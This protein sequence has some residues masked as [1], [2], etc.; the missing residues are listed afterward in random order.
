MILKC[1]TFEQMKREIIGQ[2]MSITVFGA[3]AIGTVTVPEILQQY[4]LLE[5]VLFYI[6]N[7]AAAQGQ[8]LDI[9][10]R[11]VDIEPAG[12]LSSMKENT[13]VIIAISRY[14]AVLEQLQN[15][16]NVEN[17][18]CYIMPMMCIHNFCNCASEGVPVLTD[19]PLIPKK[20]HYMWLGKKAMPDNL[21]KCIDSWKKYCPDYEIIRWDESNYDISKNSYMKDAYEAGAYG[22]VP[23]YAR[24]DILHQHGGLY[25]DTDVE[26]IRNLDDLLYQEAFCG[27]EKWQVINFGGCSGAVKGNS[28]ILQFL[29]AREKLSFFNSDGSKNK[30]TCGFYDTNVVLGNGYKINGKTQNIMGMNIYASDYFHPYD[31]MSGQTARTEHTYSIHRFNGGW[32]DDKMRQENAKAAKEYDRVYRECMMNQ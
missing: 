23:D 8:K 32:L 28:A 14:A 27:V 2:D 17:M 25:M 21:Q 22:F 11:A 9:K 16:P 7:S 20:I 5:R 13:A 30:N 10:N 1:T 19:K 26:V 12:R 3:G 31:Y 4:G 18:T 29:K 6:D 24:L 15:I